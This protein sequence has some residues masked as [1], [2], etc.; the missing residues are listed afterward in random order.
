MRKEK[1]VEAEIVNEE[2]YDEKSFF[3]PRLIA[4]VIDF[5]IVA[6]ASSLLLVFLPSDTV[7]TYDKYSKEFDNLQNDVLKGNIK[8]EEYNSK[9]KD[10]IYNKDHSS[11]PVLLIQIP[12]YIGYFIVFQYMNKGQTLG[13]KLMKVKVI[14]TKDKKLSINQIAIRALIVD[15]IAADLLI[16]G[17]VLFIGKNHYY[18]VSTGVQM[19]LAVI[20]IVILAMVLIRKDGR[21]LHD[22]LSSTKVVNVK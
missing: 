21:G 12:L 1:I 15:S 16:L 2:N 6:M 4:Y 11:V 13:K 9:V 17:S 10:A 20:T 14:S 5:F 8:V 22:M 7:N 18:Y 3:F 19:T